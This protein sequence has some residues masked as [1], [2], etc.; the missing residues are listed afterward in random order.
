MFGASSQ[1]EDAA[2]FEPNRKQEETNKPTNQHS[3]TDTDT[4]G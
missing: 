2:V 4:N 1:G 3:G